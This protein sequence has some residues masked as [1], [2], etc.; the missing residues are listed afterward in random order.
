MSMTDHT[1]QMFAEELERMVTEMPLSKVRVAELARRCHTV[2]QTFY[3]HFHDKYEL[4]AWICMRDYASAETVDGPYSPE[5]LEK[6]NESFESRRS[7]Y[8]RCF[9]EHSQNSIAEY[10][11]EFSM[12]L[13]ENAMAA[14]GKTMTH[15][16]V[17]AVRYHS[18]GI[19][20]MFGDW[21]KGNSISTAELSELL[22]ERTPEF[23]KDAFN[24]QWGQV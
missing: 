22:Y 14:A 17:L 9:S 4:V 18:H 11:A 19:V 16:Q 7:F 13:A 1:E 10:M 2:P 12:A 15:R 23:L 6:V 8:A 3:Y 5:M 24:A 21:L 20:G